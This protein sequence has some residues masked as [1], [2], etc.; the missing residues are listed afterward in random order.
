[1]QRDPVSGETLS[2]Q[3]V[4]EVDRGESRYATKFLYDG[5]WYYFTGILNRT[6]FIGSPAAYA[7]PPKKTASPATAQ[8][9]KH[10]PWIQRGAG[11][12]PRG[13][14]GLHGRRVRPQARPRPRRERPRLLP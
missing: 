12:L 5:R 14:A 11:S 6:R 10:G 3:E 8:G 1:M 2:D 13:A 9:A 7:P 4:A